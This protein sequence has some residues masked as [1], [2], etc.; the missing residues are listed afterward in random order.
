MEINESD[1]T[2]NIPVFKYLINELSN[3]Y[4]YQL[5]YFFEVRFLLRTNRF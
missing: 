2:L 4:D 5:R 3:K 1:N